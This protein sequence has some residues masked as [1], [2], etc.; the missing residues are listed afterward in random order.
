MKG[1]IA[2]IGCPKLDDA[3]SYREKLA[4]IIQAN[5]IEFIHVVYME[6]PCCG[7]L[8]RLVQGAVADSG[9][10]VPVKL[11]KIG[12]GGEILEETVL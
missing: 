9:H 10:K 11:T 7:G 5:D 3:G 8:V 12:I 2:V 6:V 4:N 1:K